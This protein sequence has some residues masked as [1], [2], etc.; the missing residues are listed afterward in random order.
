MM[1]R[2][3]RFDEMEPGFIMT[4]NQ[5]DYL[6]GRTDSQREIAL[7]AK[8][9]RTFI[10]SHPGCTSSAIKEGTGIEKPG[11]AIQWLQRR[12]FISGSTI[13]WDVIPQ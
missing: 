7:K 12:K 6:A 3:L 10:I 11:K 9:V 13:G 2:R 5:E 1:H 4:A 8:I